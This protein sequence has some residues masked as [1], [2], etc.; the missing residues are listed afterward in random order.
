MCA[1]FF[2][3]LSRSADVISFNSVLQLFVLAV[4]ANVFYIAAYLVDVFLLL[5][6]YAA[7]WRKRRWILFTI[8]F[9]FTA[10]I[11]RFISMDLFV[12]S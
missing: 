12:S 7:V 5:T 3:Y 6:E 8:G 10:I 11:A 1:H 4:M 2:Y 9:V